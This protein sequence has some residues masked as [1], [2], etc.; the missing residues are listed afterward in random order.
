MGPS[1]S[2]PPPQMQQAPL[3]VPTRE[4]PALELAR[5]REAARLRRQR[6]RQATLIAGALPGSAPLGAPLGGA[7]AKLL[8]V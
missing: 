7:G 1:I 3:P 2:A 6:G 5:Q 8:G 4:D